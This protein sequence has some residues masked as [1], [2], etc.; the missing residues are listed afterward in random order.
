M[1]EEKEVME[2]DGKRVLVVDDDH[3]ARFLMS[4]L[5]DYAGYTVVPACD[6]LAAL[7]ELRKRHFDAVVT[8]VRMPVLNGMD[9]LREVQVQ[10]AGLPVILVSGTFP[11]NIAQSDCQPFASIR[12]PYDSAL[13]LQAVRRAAHRLPKSS[14]GEIATAL[15]RSPS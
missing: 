8:D 3:H 9:L 11:E 10:Y 14:N 13:L 4:A 5:L 6:G 12:K 15:M 1:D 2:G 7:H